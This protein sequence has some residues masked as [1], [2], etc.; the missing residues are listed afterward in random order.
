MSQHPEG[1]V[2]IEGSGRRVQSSERQEAEEA[3]RERKRLRM[4][5]ILTE[6]QRLIIDNA[7]EEQGNSD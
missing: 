5:G 2:T 1:G 6:E 7:S 4:A 3:Y